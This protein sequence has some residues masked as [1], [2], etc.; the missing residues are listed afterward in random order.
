MN[1]PAPAIVAPVDPAQLRFEERLAL[2]IVKNREHTVACERIAAASPLLI[3]AY[4]PRGRGISNK[5]LRA[6]SAEKLQEFFAAVCAYN[7]RENYLGRIDRRAWTLQERNQHFVAISEEQ[8]ALRAAA[9]NGYTIRRPVEA[10]YR[11]YFS[12]GKTPSND[13]ISTGDTVNVTYKDPFSRAD[14]SGTGEIVRIE[15]SH[16]VGLI[17]HVRLP[18]NTILYLSKYN[19]KRV[20][21]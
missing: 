20:T 5:D 1:N 15:W 3:R 6:M 4:T 16:N 9:A 17:Y 2:T 11:A 18:D 12:A 8:R 10:E 19:V 7:R 21:A 14:R 13:E